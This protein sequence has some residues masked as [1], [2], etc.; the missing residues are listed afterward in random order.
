MMFTIFTLRINVIFFFIFSFALPYANISRLS[1]LDFRWRQEAA[2]QT[3]EKVSL[4][5]PS[6]ESMAFFPIHNPRLAA[7]P[8]S[9]KS[10]PHLLFL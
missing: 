1:F 6:H 7:Y 3:L 8:C 5:L 2:F 10:F 9:R 4:T